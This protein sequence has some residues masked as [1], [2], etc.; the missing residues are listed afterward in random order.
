MIIDKY[1]NLCSTGLYVG[2]DSSV[3]VATRYGLDGPRIEFRWGSRFSSPV[4]VCPGAHPASYTR[5]TAFFPG[6]KWPDRGIDHPPQLSPMLKKSRAIPLLLL[7]AI[8]AWSR[9]KFT[10][11]FLLAYIGHKDTVAP[12]AGRVRYRTNRTQYFTFNLFQ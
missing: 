1:L 12:T 11:P 8:V 6:V 10:L 5:G 9:V 3:G 7:W 2:R 4:Q